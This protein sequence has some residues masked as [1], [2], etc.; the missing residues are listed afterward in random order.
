[1]LGF[2]PTENAHNVSELKSNLK[3]VR[4]EAEVE[5]CLIF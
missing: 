3:V 1:M 4:R 5:N 2:I